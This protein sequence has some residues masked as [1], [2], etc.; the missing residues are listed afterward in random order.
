LGNYFKEKNE[1]NGRIKEVLKTLIKKYDASE[2]Q[3]LLAWIL[4]HPS[5]VYPVVGTTTKERLAASVA[6]QKIL[7]EL[8]DWFLLLKASQGHPVP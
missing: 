1:Q 8:E 5:K 4:K 6:A 3:I 7:L 2:D